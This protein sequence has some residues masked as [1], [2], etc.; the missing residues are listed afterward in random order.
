[1]FYKLSF[2]P[3]ILKLEYFVKGC[4]PNME[5]FTVTVDVFTEYKAVHPWWDR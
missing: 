1:M 5:L 4:Y 2:I 3:V